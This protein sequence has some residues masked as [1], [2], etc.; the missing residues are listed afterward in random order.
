MHKRLHGNGVEE[1]RQNYSQ[2]L[3]EYVNRRQEKAYLK[4]A[5]GKGGLPASSVHSVSLHGNSYHGRKVITPEMQMENS[6]G[7]SAADSVK[8]PGSSDRDWQDND[9]VMDS[10]R[11]SG[12]SLSSVNEDQAQEQA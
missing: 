2:Y 6:N 10:S 11:N 3:E 4:L 8:S 9:K 12:K 1:E 7:G 5:N